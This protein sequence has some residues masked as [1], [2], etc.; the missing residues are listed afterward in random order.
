MKAN[1]VNHVDD[2][3]IKPVFLLQELQNTLLKIDFM[4]FNLM[5]HAKN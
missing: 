2:V 4:F 3:N 5:F 1:S